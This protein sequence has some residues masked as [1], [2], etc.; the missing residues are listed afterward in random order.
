MSDRSIPDIKINS[1]LHRRNWTVPP[2]KMSIEMVSAN[3]VTLPGRGAS[4]LIPYP[5]WAWVSDGENMMHVGVDAIDEAAHISA[6]LD[7]GGR[8]TTP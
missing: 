2:V 7:D 8:N 1:R 3:R 5:G 4:A 6:W